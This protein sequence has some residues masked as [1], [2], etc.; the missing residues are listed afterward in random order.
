MGISSS[1]ITPFIYSLAFVFV[2]YSL[3]PSSHSSS[4][5]SSEPTKRVEKKISYR[6][7]K[8]LENILE[9]TIVLFD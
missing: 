2:N 5:S 1:S 6:A 3:V 8:T 7:K 4:S 9:S